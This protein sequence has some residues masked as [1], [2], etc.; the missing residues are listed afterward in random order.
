MSRDIDIE[1]F[2]EALVRNCSPTL[3]GLKPA[4]LFTYPGK[5]LNADTDPDHLLDAE[6]S[7]RRGGLLRVAAIADFS[8]WLSRVERG[9]CRRELLVKAAWIKGVEHPRAF[10]MTA[11]LGTDSFLLAA[12]GFDVELCERDETIA[13]LLNDALARAQSD[14]KLS[15]IVS[16]MHVV[17]GDSLKLLP[18]VSEKLDVVYLDPMFPERKKSAAVKKKFQLLHHLEKPCSNEEEMLCCALAAHPRK[19]VVK[20]PAKGPFLAGKKPSYSI[21]G[22]AVRYDV[23]LPE[24]T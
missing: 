3:A 19:V 14:P 24:P 15:D 17:E 8:D 21:S 12:A 9:A 16:R 10:D 1:S 6:V 11:G 5:Y 13:A 2:E 7:E 18:L 20:R 23:L 4:S 22:K